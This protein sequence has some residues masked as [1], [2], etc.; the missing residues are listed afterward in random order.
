MD[1]SV[2]LDV[3]DQRF[4][5]LGAFARFAVCQHQGNQEAVVSRFE[6]FFGGGFQFETL[7]AK[8]REDL[9]W[10]GRV[11]RRIAECRAEIIRRFLGESVGF[12]GDGFQFGAIQVNPGGFHPHHARQKI[13]FERPHPIQ[14]G[15]FDFTLHGS[16]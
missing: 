6:D 12:G 4:G 13:A 15:G 8:G 7:G 14:T 3:T 5:L 16:E 11:E 1:P 9:T 2:L 10:A